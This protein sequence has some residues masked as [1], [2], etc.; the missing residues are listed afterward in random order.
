MDSAWRRHS[1]G[2]KDEGAAMEQWNQHQPPSPDN[3]DAGADVASAQSRACLNCGCC[4][5]CTSSSSSSSSTSQQP[6]NAAG[7]SAGGATEVVRQ[8]P[9]SQT[10]GQGCACVRLNRDET[11]LD[12]AGRAAAARLAGSGFIL[13]SSARRGRLLGL[14]L[15]TA[16]RALLGRDDFMVRR[17]RK[18]SLPVVVERRGCVDVFPAG[19]LAELQGMHGGAE[20]VELVGANAAVSNTVS[21][22]KL[23]LAQHRLPRGWLGLSLQRLVRA[24]GWNGMGGGC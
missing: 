12:G 14:C 22:S 18:A 1:G 3:A 6:S 5:C 2:P 8:S 21:L 10:G 15:T 19:W 20:S 7:H 4:C 23:W 13:A 11:G 17:A 16:D 24:M 9:I